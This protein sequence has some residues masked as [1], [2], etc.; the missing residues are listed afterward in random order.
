MKRSGKVQGFGGSSLLSD[1][2]LGVVAPGALRLRR[3]SQMYQFV[4]RTITHRKSEVSGGVADVTED[5]VEPQWS[6]VLQGVDVHPPPGS[7]FHNSHFGARNPGSWLGFEPATWNMQGTH[8]GQFVLSEG[9]LGS[10]GTWERLPLGSASVPHGFTAD[11]QGGEIMSGNPSFPRIGDVRIRWAVCR[12]GTFSVIARQATVIRGSETPHA[13]HAGG[14][15]KMLALLAP[16]QTA[17][18]Q[19]IE[20]IVPG[21]VDAWEMFRRESASN[22]FLTNLFRFLILLGFFFGFS[23]IFSPLA[24]LLA[25][26]PLIG[27]IARLGVNIFSSVLAVTSFMVVFAVAWITTRPWYALFILIAAT[28]IF[29]TAERSSA[30]SDREDR[31]SL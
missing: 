9:L 6:A 17:N 31:R 30:R 23:F 11:L 26:A 8:L 18:G 15:G 5:V 19:T 2:Q 1:P 10:I 20:L 7:D 3:E 21:A 12:E 25:G 14:G 24:N 27:S 22:Y 13:D 16:Y 4:R 29:F 28:A